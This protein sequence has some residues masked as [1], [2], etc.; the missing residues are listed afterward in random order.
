MSSLFGSKLTLIFLVF[1][2]FHNLGQ[3]A[4]FNADFEDNSFQNW[5]GYYGSC[6]GINTPNVGFTA[7]HTIMTPGIDPV[8]QP[9]FNLS[10]VPPGAN[11]S[12][13][14]G[15][16]TGTGAQA[17]RLQYNFNIT[18]QSNMIIVKYAVVLED[19]LHSV[20]QQPRFEAQLYDSGGNPIP[21]TFYQVAAS[22]G[23][24]GFQSCGSIRY[25]DWTTFGVDVS[26]YM[27]QSIT[28]DVATGDC[29]LGGHFGYAYVSAECTTLNLS[30]VYCQNGNNNSATLTAPDGFSN[31][32]WSDPVTGQ[33][34]GN[35]QVVTLQ[36]ITQDSVTCTI[37][38]ANGCVA[39]LTTE[40]LPAEV[41]T[42]IIDTNVCFGNSTI[43]TN[44]TTTINSTIDSIFWQSNDGYYTNDI[45]FEHV[46]PQPGQWQ[47]EMIAFN[48]EG[49]SDTIQT[50]VDVFEIPVAVFNNTNTCLGDLVTLISNSYINSL[51]SITNFWQISGNTITGDTITY[52]FLQ[53]GQYSIDLITISENSCSDTITDEVI[54]YNNPVANFT[55]E[56]SCIDD[57]VNFIN[58]SQLDT[59]W[60]STPTYQWWYLQNLVSTTENWNSIFSTPGLNQITLIVRDS[61]NNQVQCLDSITLQ[62][63]VHDYPQITI[64]ADTIQCE[65]VSYILESETNLFGGEPYSVS[66]LLSSVNYSDTNWVTYQHSSPGT[67][68]WQFIAES[69]FGCQTDTIINIQVMSTPES[70][71]LSFTTP[72]C[73][74]DDFYLSAV[75]VENSQIFWQGPNNFQSNQF[76]ITFPIGVEGMGLYSAYIVSEW[77]CQSEVSDL[78]ASITYIMSFDDFD[79]PNVITAN[80]DGKNDELDIKKYF[81]TCDEFTLQIFNRWGNLVWTQSQQ[82]NLFN[83]KD[84]T[85]KDLVDGIYFFKLIFEKG[86]KSGFLHIVR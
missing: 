60:Q 74:G 70:P 55:I 58:Q 3:S 78:W 37:T 80:L 75:E 22:S 35:G 26:G 5:T 6:C 47:I 73:P 83:G 45:N 13:R 12:A 8:V 28:L 46:F 43:I 21:C 7:Q 18:P 14:V 23:V 40:V 67:Y 84:L 69:E 56:E 53:P 64:V 50:V 61:F 79:F 85:G 52:N 44:L 38:S 31:Y 11:F 16:G 77:G 1:F 15:D 41:I 59:I 20:S 48:S 9:C 68:Q 82:T 65:D 33:Q 62:F 17:A 2:F 49:C 32:V 57:P 19:P 51:D 27:G 63:F 10:V 86:E 66:W 54:I 30:A 36:N 39:N 76:D 24:P 42:Q 72:E 25:K 81:M 71:I 4:C 34:L 29:S